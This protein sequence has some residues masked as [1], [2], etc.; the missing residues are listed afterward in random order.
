MVGQK[1]ILLSDVFSQFNYK[2]K[3]EQYAK[4]GDTVEII[5]ESY[6]AVIVKGKDGN[7]FT[8]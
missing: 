7:I 4:K 1:V 3:K 8:N 5:S 2:G 6:P